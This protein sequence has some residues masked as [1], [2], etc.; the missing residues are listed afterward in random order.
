MADNKNIF[1]HLK[2]DL[3]FALIF[4]FIINLGCEQI[5][6]EKVLKV[7]T[8]EI[9]DTSTTTATATGVIIDA[10]EN[11]VVDHGHCWSTSQEP[12]TNLLTKTMLGFA[13]TAG[14]FES[15]I[16]GLAKGI[17]YYVR[18][19]ATNSEKTIYG[20]EINFS[21]SDTLPT[22]STVAVINITWNSAESGGNVIDDGGSPVTQKGVCWNTSQNPTIA[23]DTTLNGSSIGS[24]SSFIVGLALNSTYYVKAYATNNEGTGY[25]DEIMFKTYGI[26][27][28]S[29]DGQ[30]YKTVEIGAQWWMAENLNFYSNSGSWY[31][32]NDSVSYAETYGR[33]YTW[34]TANN[35]CPAGWHLPTDSEWKELEIYLGMTLVQ[36]DNTGWRGSNQ[37]I[38]LSIDGNSHFVALPAGY[39]FYTGAFYD[40]S[41]S[42]Y[43]W[44]STEASTDFAWCRYITPDEYT[45]VNRSGFLKESGFSVRCVQ[46]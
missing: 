22:I 28:D 35:V 40:L 29:R 45:E 12:D 5:E 14:S 18:A 7:A 3:L 8:G 41:T 27:N 10:G 23:N 32:E 46:D 11:N 19:Y 9:T 4:L 31:Y 1:I 16:T 36:T 24:F 44:S 30:S 37:G 33:L 20:D 15:N 13:N 38:Q 2:L 34:E 17:T 43:F 39:R 25:G 21:T 6:P 26:L 42:A